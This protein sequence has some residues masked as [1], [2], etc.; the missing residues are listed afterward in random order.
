MGPCTSAAPHRYSFSTPAAVFHLY[1]GPV[2]LSCRLRNSV[3]PSR[4]RKPDGS[5]PT[6]CVQ[7]QA[8]P[9]GPSGDTGTR[10]CQITVCAWNPTGPRSFQVLEV[11]SRNV[12]DP[13]QSAAC[14]WVPEMLL[15]SSLTTQRTYFGGVCWICVFSPVGEER[16]A[17]KRDI[18]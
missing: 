1:F 3:S 7:C 12:V 8:R 18:F 16:P 17:T 15:S 5:P 2:G 6:S 13:N 10:P 11:S 9:T 4:S 14:G